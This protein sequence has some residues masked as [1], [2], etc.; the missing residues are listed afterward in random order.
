MLQDAKVVRQAGEGYALPFIGPHT[1][2]TAPV[3]CDITALTDDEIDADGYIK[4]GVPLKKDGTLVGTGERLY[5]VTIEPKKVAE[6][7]DATSLAAASA[8]Q[9]LV[10]MIIGAVNRAAA[11]DILGRAYTADEVAGFNDGTIVLVE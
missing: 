8:T 7:N 6:G 10:L 1:A 3:E 5:G 4:P 9:H 11:E 2:Y